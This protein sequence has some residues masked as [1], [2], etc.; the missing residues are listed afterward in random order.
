MVE[1]K[2]VIRR[3][4]SEVELERLIKSKVQG[5]T[6]VKMKASK[7]SKE[8]IEAIKKRNAEIGVKKMPADYKVGYKKPPHR[9]Q[10]GQVM[11]PNGHCMS[12]EQRVLRA[13]TNKTLAETIQ[14]V[15]TLV[16]KEV[17]KLLKAKETNA[18]EAIILGSVLDAVKHRNYGK[19]EQLLERVIGK[20]SDKVDMT[21]NGQSIN[22]A[23]SDLAKIKTMVKEIENEY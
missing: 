19:L 20:V 3:T 15:I 4:K 23:S 9:F 1:K 6:K 14:K 22:L 16:P 12:L 10:K 8:E 5:K 21:T 13:T 11:N 2:K 17:E 7:K 18:L